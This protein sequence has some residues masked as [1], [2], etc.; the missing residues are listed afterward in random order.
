MEKCIFTDNKQIYLIEAGAAS[1]SV[2][3]CDFTDNDSFTFHGNCA[4]GSNSSF[5]DCRF[6]YNEPALEIEKELAFSFYFNTRLSGVSFVDCDFGESTF[7]D[8]NRA[9]FSTSDVAG[10]I[11]GE[12]SLTMIVAIVALI[13]SVASVV[14]NFASSKKNAASERDDRSDDEE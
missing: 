8:R 3:D 4:G 12:G 13:V 6:S 7:N 5:T 1:L 9:S 2:A 11:I 10:S 14:V